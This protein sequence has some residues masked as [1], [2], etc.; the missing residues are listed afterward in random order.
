M[1]E[2]IIKKGQ[3]ITLPSGAIVMPNGEPAEKVVTK[4]EV[5][6]RVETG[7]AVTDPFADEKV[8]PLRRTIGKL[9]G[10]ARTVNPI[11]LVL[12]YSMWGM[13]D[14]SIARYLSID[15]DQ[16]QSIKSNEHFVKLRKEIIES[17]RHAETGSVHGFIAQKAIAAAENVVKKMASRD[18]A[19]SL[20]AAQDVLDRGGFRPAD[21][22]E[23][24]HTFEDD[25]RIRYIEDKP[26]PVIDVDL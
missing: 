19:V 11:M 22:I 15:V 6:A 23:H 12:S 25:L 17:L 1:A 13:D 20:R 7:R 18:E 2:I 5:T 24:A 8:E 21:R 4:D 26:T 3:P 9:P 16:V 10:D 14:A